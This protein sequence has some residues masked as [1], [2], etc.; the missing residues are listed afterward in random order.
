MQRSFEPSVTSVSHSMGLEQDLIDEI[1]D[2]KTSEEC[3]V[4]WWSASISH[5][6]SSLFRISKLVA[7]STTTDRHAR[8]EAAGGEPF[9]SAYDIA[10]LQHKFEQLSA[11]PWLL[12][13][14][15]RAN[16][17]RRNYFRYC[18]THRE[19]LGRQ[20]VSHFGEATTKAGD[21]DQAQTP[22]HPNLKTSAKSAYSK[23][24]NMHTIASS[25]GVVDMQAVDDGFDDAASFST[26]A[27]SVTNDEANQALSVPKLTDIAQPGTDFECPYC[28][29]MQKF[30]GQQGWKYVQRE[31]VRSAKGPISPPIAFHTRCQLYAASDLMMR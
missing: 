20:D 1:L 15:G 17:T 7:K 13:R 28:F 4:T 3:Q 9:D 26:L 21:L 25:L 8:A 30:N 22:H 18:R 2:L 12:K 5:L 14:L 16:A 10:H 23:P 31:S 27:N 29:T 24:S 11:K 6:I 19:K